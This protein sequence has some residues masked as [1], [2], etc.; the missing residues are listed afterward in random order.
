MSASYSSIHPAERIDM[1]T[2]MRRASIAASLVGAL[3]L[4][5]VGCSGNATSTV[6]SDANSTTNATASDT[7]STSSAAAT[8]TATTTSSETNS[9]KAAASSSYVNA[10]YGVRY[11]LPEG[12]EFTEVN[13]DLDFTAGSE[14]AFDAENEA[15]DIIYLQVTP[16][17]EKLKASIDSDYSDIDEF[18]QKYAEHDGATFAKNLEGDGCTIIDKVIGTHALRN[19][20]ELCTT[21]IQYEEDGKTTFV[22]SAYAIRNDA[23]LHLTLWAWEESALDSMMDGLTLS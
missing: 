10:E 14:L 7:G 23:L 11:D 2:F 21:L 16:L 1:R 20:E 5:I 18:I 13:D 3:A 19:G 12:F 22:S 4:G 8:D 17:T 9:S 6:A 15:H